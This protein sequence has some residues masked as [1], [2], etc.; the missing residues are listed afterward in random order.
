MF[1][2]PRI[3]YKAFQA[4]FIMKLEIQIWFQDRVKVPLLS[5]SLTIQRFILWWKD[6]FLPHTAVSFFSEALFHAVFLCRFFFFSSHMCALAS[7]FAYSLFVCFFVKPIKQPP[8]SQRFMWGEFLRAFVSDLHHLIF[9]TAIRRSAERVGPHWASISPPLERSSAL[10]TWEPAVHVH[11]CVREKKRQTE[12][13]RLRRLCCKWCFEH[14]LIVKCPCFCC[15]LDQEATRASFVANVVFCP[16]CV[17][18]CA[19]T[20][21][22]SLTDRP[23]LESKSQE[24]KMERGST[25]DKRS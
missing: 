13:K 2:Y 25:A 14:P 17:C 6:C 8:P 7:V 24:G 5:P 9:I 1:F 22:V 10:F 15:S 4:F 19:H 21:T 12:S 18:V 11:E 16:C 23:S 20:V 3:K